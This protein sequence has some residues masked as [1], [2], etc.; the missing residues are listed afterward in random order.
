[1]QDQGL[2]SMRVRLVDAD[3]L[4]TQAATQLMAEM[5]I[6]YDRYTKEEMHEF[7]QAV[8]AES[9]AIWEE[10]ILW[11]TCGDDKR[12][13]TRMLLKANMQIQDLL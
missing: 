6:G 4:F 7:T 13:R 8:V 1:M 9:S 3:E 2:V 11:V 5:G 10:F 12:E